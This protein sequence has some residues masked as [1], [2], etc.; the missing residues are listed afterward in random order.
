MSQPNA[1]KLAKNGTI[2]PDWAAAVGAAIMI[3]TLLLTAVVTFT[4]D[5]APA[6]A[7]AAPVIAERFIAFRA[8]PNATDGVIIRDAESGTVIVAFGPEE[9]GFVRGME[10]VVAFERQ[11]MG[12]GM[13]APFKL[14]AHQDGRVFLADPVTGQVIDINAFGPD[15]A[16]AF[17]ALL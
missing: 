13:D 17:A 3:G 11:K 10:R 2:I 7:T 6:T 1:L 14:T 8:N 15:N 16:E 9:G 12:Q 5:R 4:R